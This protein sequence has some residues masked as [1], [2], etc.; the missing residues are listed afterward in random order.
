MER[1]DP[2][3]DDQSPIEDEDRSPCACGDSRC[4]IDGNDATNVN[5]KG[6]WFSADCAGLCFFC[7]TVDD[8]TQ[9]VEIAGGWLAH[10]GCDLNRLR[11]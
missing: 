9:L 6:R 3:F 10:E 8:R 11:R 1:L 4:W 5:V 7:G 2:R